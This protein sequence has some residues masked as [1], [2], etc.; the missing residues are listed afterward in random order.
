MTRIVR[1]LHSCWR[2]Y[3]TVEWRDGNG[4]GAGAY[5]AVPLCCWSAWRGR[6]IMEEEY[7]RTRRH[8]AKASFS[9]SQ[10]L[11]LA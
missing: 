8:V 7:V 5:R 11:W 6:A 10:W 4:N 9:S 1:S 2:P 3:R